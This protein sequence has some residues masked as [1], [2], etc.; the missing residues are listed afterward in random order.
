MHTLPPRVSHSGWRLGQ[1]LP[2]RIMIPHVAGSQVKSLADAS[3][4]P[5]TKEM[6]PASNVGVPLV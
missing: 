3:H 1:F 5:E 2:A 6:P 4:A